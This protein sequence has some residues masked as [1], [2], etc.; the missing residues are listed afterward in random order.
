MPK[1]EGGDTIMVNGS[2]VELENIGKA[3]ERYEKDNEETEET[4]EETETTEDN[5]I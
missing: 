4:E 2:Y 5:T 3:Y 1:I